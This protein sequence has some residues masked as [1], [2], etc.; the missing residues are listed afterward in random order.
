MPCWRSSDSITDVPLS[1][2]EHVGLFHSHLKCTLS[3][4][5]KGRAT[6]G[7][8]PSPRE[9]GELHV[10][11]KLAA[12]RQRLRLDV[13]M[14]VRD[15]PGSFVSIRASPLLPHQRGLERGKVSPVRGT[16]YEQSGFV[17]ARRRRRARR[18]KSAAHAAVGTMS[19]RPTR[20]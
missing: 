9:M 8:H 2:K 4:P 17:A 11:G 10:T 13:S 15:M 7:V 20:R 6:K 14:S 16:T 1:L 3:D 19:R 12:Y 18:K 5:A